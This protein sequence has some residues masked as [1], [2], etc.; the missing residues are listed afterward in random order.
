[1]L[2][3][4]L[5][6]LSVVCECDSVNGREARHASLPAASGGGRCRRPAASPELSLSCPA[7]KQAVRWTGPK[8]RRERDG[9]GELWDYSGSTCELSPGSR[10]SGRHATWTDY[11]SGILSWADSNWIDA[12]RCC[13]VSIPCVAAPGQP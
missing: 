4:P 12:M 5:T 9:S 7:R 1:M 2:S 11:C 13:A 8:G 10:R 6:Q 3:P